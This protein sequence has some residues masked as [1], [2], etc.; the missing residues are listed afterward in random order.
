MK[1][2]DP[3]KLDETA[4]IDTFHPDGSAS[5]VVAVAGPCGEPDCEAQHTRLYLVPVVGFI[6]YAIPDKNVP[7]KAI[8]VIRPAIMSSA[9]TI[10][11]YL[12]VP[13][14]LKFIAVLKVSE[15]VGDIARGIYRE[16]FGGEILASEGIE[17]E[18]PN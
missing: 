14:E 10:G 5:W 8:S 1:L 2:P 3:E 4:E 9:G 17:I 16:R 6:H 7:D 18:A 12:D 11:D 13:S 15:H